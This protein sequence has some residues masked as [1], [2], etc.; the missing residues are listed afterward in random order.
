M[1]VSRKRDF[2]LCFSAEVSFTL[3]THN[4][5]YSVLGRNLSGL[6][7]SEHKISQQHFQQ[8]L[9]LLHRSGGRT[10]NGKRKPPRKFS[11]EQ[12]YGVLMFQSKQAKSTINFNSVNK[13]RHVVAAFALIYIQHT[14]LIKRVA[15]LVLYYD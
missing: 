6:G 8:I 4:S 7:I 11:Q 2:S 15:Y 5:C 3:L 14:S 1:A 9:G 12:R 10:E 13:L